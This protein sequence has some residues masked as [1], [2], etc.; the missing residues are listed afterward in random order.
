[1]GHVAIAGHPRAGESDTRF[2]SLGWTPESHVQRRG[3][4]LT[5][6]IVVHVILIAVCIVVPLLMDDMVP[7][8][9]DAVRAFFVE[10]AAVLPPPP[11]PP[12]PAPGPKA[13]AVKPPAPV[14]DAKF[15]APID[16]PQALPEPEAS[17]DAF[18]I[19]GGVAGG[20]EGGVPGGVVGG[21]VGGLPTA[22]AAPPRVRVGGMINA[23]KLTNK[24][25]PVY[26]ELARSARVGGV[27]ILEAVVGTNGHVQ[28]VRVLRGHPLLDGAAMEAVRA[29]RYQP[30]LL[31]GVPTEFELTVT[32]MFNISSG[33]A[34]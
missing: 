3:A 19:E 22:P 21:V 1:M 8:P 18:G 30:L 16:I 11:P 25:A 27:V 33:G 29:W 17:F 12:P 31:N 13:P 23:P 5:V 2:V 15:V 34:S 6:S 14:Q 26:P 20:V 28:S 10:P 9:A 4:T 24:V 7:E 32:L